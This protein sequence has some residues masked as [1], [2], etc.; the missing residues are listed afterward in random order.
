MPEK[1]YVRPTV[2]I[3]ASA[4]RDL[5]KYILEQSEC[6]VSFCPQLP[7]EYEHIAQQIVSSGKIEVIEG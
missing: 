2:Q 4:L 3:E 5:M 7:R 1:T 6:L